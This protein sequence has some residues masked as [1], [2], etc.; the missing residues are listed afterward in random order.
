[1]PKPR[2]VNG[3]SSHRAGLWRRFPRHRFPAGTHAAAAL[4]RVPAPA[5]PL[6]T[7][8]HRRCHPQWRLPATDDRS[9]RFRTDVH[10]SVSPKNRLAPR[11]KRFRT[12]PSIYSGSMEIK[13]PGFRSGR[14]L[15]R[16]EIFFS[17]KRGIST[18]CLFRQAW[19][20]AR[21]DLQLG[22]AQSACQRLR[23]HEDVRNDLS[24]IVGLAGPCG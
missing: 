9:Y 4:H 16:L 24:R 23:P 11:S 8:D 2:T 12:K 5:L 18:R 15:E 10:S 17:S 22:L 3:F 1:M 19:Q 14:F 21:R 6:R 7:S 13:M 20:S